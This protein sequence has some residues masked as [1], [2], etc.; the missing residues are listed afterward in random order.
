MIVG[1]TEA[2]G[3]RGEVPEVSLYL[4]EDIKHRV[5]EAARA[6]GMSED[7]YMR[8]A[9]RRALSEEIVGERPRPR[10]PLFD[11]GDPTMAERVDDILA[12]GFGRDGLD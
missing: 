9:I 2:P 12:E 7:A 10:L 5:A 6:H 4:P 1:V 3:Y 11:S 8:E